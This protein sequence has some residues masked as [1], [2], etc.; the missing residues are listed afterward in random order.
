VRLDELWGESR[1]APH[2]FFSFAQSILDR[3]LASP[4]SILRGQFYQY[5]RNDLERDVVRDTVK[6]G[7][8]RFWAGVD[9]YKESTQYKEWLRL[10]EDTSKSQNLDALEALYKTRILIARDE[11]KNQLRLALEPLPP[12]ELEERDSSQVQVAAE[13]FMHEELDVPYYFG[14]ERFCLLA[15]NNIEELLSIAADAYDALQAK[16]I[17]R[18][19]TMLSAYDQEK[20]VRQ[21]ADRRWSF[22]P[23]AHAEGARTQRLLSG[24]GAYCRTRTFLPNAPYAPGV[25]GIRL[26]HSELRRLEEPTADLGDPLSVLRNVLSESVAEN[27]LICRETTTN[28]VPD[29]TIFYLNRTLCAY[30][31]LPLQYGGWQDVTMSDMLTWMH[32]QYERPV[33]ASP[34]RASG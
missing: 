3:R 33:S 2:Q 24:M 1:R 25:T 19:E 5:L 15:T 31:N 7:I 21:A 20:I 23:K 30:F 9:Q 34:R 17:V 32:G 4:K 8:E 22:I 18:R 27:L 12:Q 10:A 6:K 13:I 26:V 11:R 28:D 14:I 29:G 16:H